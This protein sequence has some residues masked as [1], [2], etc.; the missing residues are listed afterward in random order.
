MKLIRELIQTVL[1]TVAGVALTFAILLHTTIENSPQQLTVEG[2]TC[3]APEGWTAHLVQVGENLSALAGIVG[4]T[5]AELVV[6]NCLQGDLH[7]G[8]TV[9]LPPP[10][11]NRDPCGPP[12]DWILYA[13]QP[14]DSLPLLALQYGI[15]EESIWHANCMSETMTF[16]P[17]FRIYLPP[18]GDAP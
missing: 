14:G 7:P 12:D 15:S 16:Q 2:R 10:D 11:Q 3:P 1:L 4:V 17:G 13:L 8:D 18:N 9:Y 6:A 5:P